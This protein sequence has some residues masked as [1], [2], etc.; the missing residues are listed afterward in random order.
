MSESSEQTFVVDLLTTLRQE[1]FQLRAWGGF[2]QRS[3][4]MS[5]QTARANPLLR[6]SWWR[7]TA[8]AGSLAL[9]ILCGNIFFLG[10][11][12]TLRLLPGFLL[13]VIWQQSDLFWHLGLNRSVRDGRL[14]QRLGMANTLT[15]VRGLGASYLLGRLVGGLATSATLA[16]WIFMAGIVTDILD[17]RV[18]SWSG[19]QRKLGQIADAEVDVCLFFALTIVLLQN[20]VLLPWV[21]LIMLLRFLVPLGVALFSY[22]AFAHPVQFGSTWWGKGAGLVCYFY[23]LA[24]LAPPSLAAVSHVLNGPLLFLMICLFIIAPL[25]QLARVRTRVGEKREQTGGLE[26]SETSAGIIRE[27]K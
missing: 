1:R 23:I 17:G 3:W 15:W 24:L 2:I 12:D 4:R 26:Q 8:L 5:W 7:L 11:G 13:C 6:Q 18:A 25:A 19:T 10:V 27:Q 9:L 14:F 20:G 22:L 16:F 21:A